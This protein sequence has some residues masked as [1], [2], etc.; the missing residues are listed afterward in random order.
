MCATCS[1]ERIGYGAGMDAIETIM[2]TRA[3][4]RF[5]DQS[6]DDADGR[7]DSD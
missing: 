7:F 3:I 4:R 2:T 6:V 5:T 1:R